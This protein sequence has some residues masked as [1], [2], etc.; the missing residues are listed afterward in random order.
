MATAG[1]QKS[2]SNPLLRLANCH[3]K[4]ESLIPAELPNSFCILLGA[5]IKLQLTTRFLCSKEE[6]RRA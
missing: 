6:R 3:G 5:Q 2:V 4:G 1:T